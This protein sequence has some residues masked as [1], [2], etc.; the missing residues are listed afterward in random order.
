MTEVQPGVGAALAGQSIALDPLVGTV[1][2]EEQPEE[3]VEALGEDVL[4]HA[5]VDDGLLAPVGFCQQQVRGGC[6]CCQCCNTRHASVS[7]FPAGCT[8]AFISAVCLFQSL[9]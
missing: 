7:V 9:I 1:D 2:D 5:A 4:P 6:F 3:L 8:Y